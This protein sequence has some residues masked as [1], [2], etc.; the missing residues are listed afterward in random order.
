MET[1][2]LRDALLASVFA[3]DARDAAPLPEPLPVSIAKPPPAIPE[4]AEQPTA[5]PKAFPPG[6]CPNDGEPFQELGGALR[7]QVCGLQKAMWGPGS[8]SRKEL[9]SEQWQE[10]NK[11]RGTM[12]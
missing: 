5:P 3:K 1:N 8:P 6:T 4:P 7:C 12:R 11:D 10:R 2:G 9:E